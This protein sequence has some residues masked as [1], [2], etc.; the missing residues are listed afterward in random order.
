MM[1]SPECL[2]KRIHMFACF[3]VVFRTVAWPRTWPWLPGRT[4]HSCHMVLCWQRAARQPWSWRCT[5]RRLRPWLTSMG[6][7]CHWLT[8]W[9]GPG[10]QADCDRIPG[11][12][13]SCTYNL[14]EHHVHPVMLFRK[15]AHTESLH[16]E[17][18]STSLINLRCH[19][20]RFHD[21]LWTGLIYF[22]SGKFWPAAFRETQC[23]WPSDLESSDLEPELCSCAFALSDSEPRA[24]GAPAE[25]GM[26]LKG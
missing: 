17:A 10:E 19:L 20:A 1:H 23:G 24:V 9:G 21:S 16:G 8:R 14:N 22:L 15:P 4:R 3:G 5:M 6:S 7:T 26:A 25:A 2:G 13:N 11:E 18:I 12:P